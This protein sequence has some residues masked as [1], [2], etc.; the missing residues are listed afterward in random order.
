MLVNKIALFIVGCLAISL[1][2]TSQAAPSASPA[3]NATQVTPS[4]T[5]QNLIARWQA[6]ADTLGLS[7]E[8]FKHALDQY[9]RLV[10]DNADPNIVP[11]HQLINSDMTAQQKIAL[12]NQNRAMFAAYLGIP[13][14][15]LGDF[16]RL[17]SSYVLP[18]A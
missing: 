8:T 6:D 16:E 9:M 17:M 5:T 12:L 10:Y 18:Q 14:N 11:L 15:A 13:V 3:A 2:F 1:S 7:L 4:A